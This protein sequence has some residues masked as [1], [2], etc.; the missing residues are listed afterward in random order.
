MNFDKEV[1]FNRDK[2]PEFLWVFA[3]RSHFGSSLGASLAWVVAV[4]LPCLPWAA[5]RAKQEVRRA[6]WP[7]GAPWWR[8]QRPGIS[9]NVVL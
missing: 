2:V 7:S 6:T 8:R 3:L 1:P 9:G 5:C 4:S